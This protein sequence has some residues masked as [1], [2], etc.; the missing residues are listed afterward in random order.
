MDESI[1]KSVMVGGGEGDDCPGSDGRASGWMERN[2]MS[3]SSS[4]CH[5]EH[6]K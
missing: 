3:L 5:P 6:I 4:V 2:S 1:D